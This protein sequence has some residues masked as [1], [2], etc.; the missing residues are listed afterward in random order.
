MKTKQ[1]IILYYGAHAAFV[2]ALFLFVLAIWFLSDGFSSFSWQ[3]F[4]ENGTRNTAP[5]VRSLFKGLPNSG[6]MLSYLLF[7]WPAFG[8]RKGNVT[9]R[10]VSAGSFLM[11]L[12]ILYLF[13][14]S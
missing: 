5:I 11:I 14:K 9:D 4:R 10:I 13:I 8:L 3:H 7:V 12:L 1:N 2:T 6:L